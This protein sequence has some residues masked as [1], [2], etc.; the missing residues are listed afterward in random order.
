MKEEKSANAQQTEEIARTIGQRLKG[1]EVIVLISELGGGKTTFTHGLASGIGSTDN[2]ASPTFTISRVYNGRDLD[3]HHF[4]FYRLTDPG[5]I[6]HELIEAIENPKNIVV[7]E[8]P[9]LVEDVLP[10][11][12]LTV[13]FKI[14]D[15]NVR[16]LLFK[17]PENLSYLVGNDDISNSDGQTGIGDWLI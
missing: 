11:D 9:D 2:V 5:V 15:D 1:G 16:N 17:D 3:I 10:A 8:W 14:I 7:I 4:D 6:S 13:E 12:R